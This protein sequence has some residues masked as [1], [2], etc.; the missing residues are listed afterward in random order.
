MHMHAKVLQ[1][2]FSRLIAG[3]SWHGL[4]WTNLPCIVPT[5]HK[6]LAIVVHELSILYTD[7]CRFCTQPRQSFERYFFL[8]E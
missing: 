1:C 7:V 8:A 6:F 2:K 3:H 5:E 4:R